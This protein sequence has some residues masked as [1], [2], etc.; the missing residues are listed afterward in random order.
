MNEPMPFHLPLK[1]TD[2]IIQGNWV[3]AS[4]HIIINTYGKEETG[5]SQM[6]RGHWVTDVCYNRSELGLFET[7]K[8]IFMRFPVFD[9]VCNALLVERGTFQI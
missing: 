7:D 3:H 2:Q 1:T 6:G 5:K 4:R 8:F 9:V